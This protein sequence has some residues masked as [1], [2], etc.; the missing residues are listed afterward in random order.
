M[1]IQCI[2][3]H[4]EEIKSQKHLIIFLAINKGSCYMIDFEARKILSR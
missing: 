4:I 3:F 1:K 2:F